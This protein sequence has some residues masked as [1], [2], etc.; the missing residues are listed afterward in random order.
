MTYH[1]YVF[2]CARDL[3][4]AA[5]EASRD[6]E[7]IDRQLDAMGERAASVGGSSLGAHVRSTGEP[8]RMA[9]RVAALVDMEAPLLERRKSDHAL[10]SFA[11]RVL[12]G[13]GE[14]SGLHA[15][16][17]WRADAL[18]QH[19]LN[20]LTWAQVGDVLGYSEQHVWR[21]AQVALDVCDGYGFVDVMRGRGSA[22]NW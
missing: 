20:G 3:F 18:A 2:S 14:S 17:G 15:L 7:R 4:E 9:S 21:E 13:D 16:V 22:E 8:D 6:A 10:M 12:Y 19:Y 5:A 1:G 11:L